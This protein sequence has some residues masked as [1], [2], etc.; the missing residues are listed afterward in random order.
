MNGFKEFLADVFNDPSEY[1]PMFVRLGV[2]LAEAA[3]A[4]VDHWRMASSRL[5]VR[6]VCD[7]PFL[8]LIHALKAGTIL[9]LGRVNDPSQPALAP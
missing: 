5:P 4:T 6:F 7:R 9:F 8:L 2:L 3:A 1:L